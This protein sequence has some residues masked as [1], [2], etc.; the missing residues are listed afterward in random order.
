MLIWRLEASL[1]DSLYARSAFFR[2][3]LVHAKFPGVIS[4]TP[5]ATATAAAQ[6]SAPYRYMHNTFS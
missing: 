4:K 6:N 1:F 2:V 5:C 3:A